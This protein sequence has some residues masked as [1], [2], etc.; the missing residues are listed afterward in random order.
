MEVWLFLLRAR[1]PAH[2]VD[3][4]RSQCWLCCVVV[5]S[6]AGVSQGYAPYCGRAKEGSAGEKDEIDDRSLSL[7]RV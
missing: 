3:S 4:T 6:H 5:D 1:D 2:L 7:N